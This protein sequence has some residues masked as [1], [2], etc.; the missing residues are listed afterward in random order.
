MSNPAEIPAVT[1]DRIQTGRT[2]AL[3]VAL[4]GL[5]GSLVIAGLFEGTGQF[6]RSYLASFVW[7]F[8]F[9]L[10]SLVLLMIQNISGGV[11]G[12][13]IRRLLE[14]AAGTLPALAVLFL[15]I[16]LG[17]TSFY[18][19]IGEKQL[20]TK[21]VEEHHFEHPRLYEWAVPDAVIQNDK[22][23][24][25][26]SAYLNVPFWIIR[27]AVSFGLWIGLA[28]LLISLSDKQDREN[29]PARRAAIKLQMK[30]ISAPGILIFALSI[31]FIS[32][33]W[34]MSLEPHWYSTMYPVI[35][36]FSQLL[37]SM[38]LAI[39]AL[40]TFYDVKP[41]DKSMTR[42]HL[43]DLGSFLLGFVIFWTYISFSQ[44]LLMWSANLKEEV[45][46]YIAR[47]TGGWEIITTILGFG[48]FLLPFLLLLFRETKRRKEIIWKIAAF[49]LV[50][51]FFD[52]FWQVGGAFHHGH[53]SIHL[54][55]LSTLALLGGAWTW[56]YL[57]NI[58]KRPL[59]PLHDE[60]EDSL[61]IYGV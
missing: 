31:M 11:W 4:G 54:L 3:R 30:T 18:D 38:A 8:A 35:F 12:Y 9:G 13:A 34:V 41:F 42:N 50:M 19:M 39:I 32:T 52:I 20:I 28:W 58:S 53:L 21:T 44:F 1:L 46:Y 55:D 7:V 6:L 36:G 15:P 61:P 40:V 25:A 26:K 45:P 47:T 56:V 24:Q 2:L 59:L 14:A 27:S 5:V 43:R 57:G 22:I 23:L 49:V 60:R 16:L 10:G 51:R 48:H 37:S 17:F 33:D 29:D